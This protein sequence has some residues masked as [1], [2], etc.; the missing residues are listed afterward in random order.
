MYPL[1]GLHLIVKYFVGTELGVANF[2]QRHFDW[3][4]NCLWYEEI[5][6]ERNPKKTMFV[7]GGKDSIIDASVGRLAPPST[8]T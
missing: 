8:Y 1:Q 7:L 4:A 6:N 3:S 5:P 2:L